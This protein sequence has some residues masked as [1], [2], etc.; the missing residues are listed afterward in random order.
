MKL[1]V[2]DNARGHLKVKLRSSSSR[3]SLEY[4]ILK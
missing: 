2:I 1:K 3:M 4:K